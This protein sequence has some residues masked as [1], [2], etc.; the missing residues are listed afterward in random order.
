MAKP[1]IMDEL[2]HK[3]PHTPHLLW[4]G[5][6][7]PREDK[8]LSPS[9]VDE[10]LTG[11]LV[12]E[13][14]VDGANL[15]LSLGPDGRLRAQ[16]RGNYLAPGRSHAQWNPL[17]AWLAERRG[18][19]EPALRDG[20]MLYGEW[21]YA[22]HTVPYD[23]LPDRFLGFDVLELATGRFWSVDR[24]NAWLA[25][26]N[27]VPVPE[28]ARGR[29][30][31]KQLGSLLGWSAVGAVPREGLYLRREAGGFLIG[32]AKVVSAVF[33]QAIETHWT[34]RPVVP[35]SLALARV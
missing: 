30:Q 31:L 34:R 14:K 4:L 18:V 16:S 5:L 22:R 10:F 13:E 1:L 15:G 25:E 35:N 23:G 17:W 12:I 11:E 20:L 32:R 6:G 33:K 29:F 8:V 19:L 3:F 9:E 28:V 21:C 2:F 27:V 24:R 7:Q 26:V